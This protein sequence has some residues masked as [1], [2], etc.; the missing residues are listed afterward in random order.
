VALHLGA[1]RLPWALKRLVLLS[2]GLRVGVGAR[3]L[4]EE[5]LLIIILD[6]L[7]SGLFLLLL[8]Q[9]HNL[10][11]LKGSLLGV[12]GDLLLSRRPVDHLGVVHGLSRRLLLALA[13]LAV[14]LRSALLLIDGRGLTVELRA[15]D[16]ASSVQTSSVLDG[17]VL[18]VPQIYIC[19]LFIELALAMEHEL[20]AL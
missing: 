4:L 11:V 19:S 2:L 10:V 3:P 8:M 13:L 14:N 15:V 6:G 12:Q 20:V 7:S 18:L 16:L 5:N 1:V 17:F 9:A